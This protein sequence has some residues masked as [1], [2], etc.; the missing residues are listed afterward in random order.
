V[1]LV[2]GRAGAI[3]VVTDLQ[4]RGWDGGERLS[5][6][7][8]IGLSV[9][10][11]GEGPP[12]LSISS[13]RA[14]GER[15]V[16]TVRSAG[17]E[18]R[19]A[20][21]RLRLDEGR[22]GSGE[23]P[24][25][26]VR[27]ETLVH[28]APGGSAEAV[29]EGA[30]GA[31]ASVVVDDP[32]GIQGDDVRYVVLDGGGPPLVKVVT[33]SGDVGRDAFYVDQALKA[34]GEAGSA[35]RVEGLAAGRAESW[36]AEP[37]DGAA[38]VLLVSTRG[39][40]RRGREVIATWVRKGGGLLIAAGAEVEGD[41]TADILG[42]AVTL[43]VPTAQTRVESPPA[44]IVPVDSRHPMFRAFGRDSRSLGF[45]R[46]DRV[47]QVNGDTCRTL[48]RLTSGE[49]V[50]VECA[51][52]G[53]VLVFASD[54][55]HRWN[56]FPVHATFVPFV[57]EAV[58]YLAGARVQSQEY[59]IGDV[60][61]G[62]PPRPGTAMLNDAST[63][64]GRLVAVNVDPGESEP[65]R[66]SRDAF[67]DP[68]ARVDEPAVAGVPESAREQEDHQQLWRYALWLMLAVLILESALGARTA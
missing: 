20:R 57:Q 4:A 42:G 64:T 34:S 21:V 24:E 11:V 23:G 46:F 10:D 17:G 16:A 19:E 40:D 6:P 48:A 66:V 68:V 55:D 27:G 43:A 1:E 60:P 59:L 52:A 22:T 12:N 31:A 7:S 44:S 47:A 36:T 8:A 61:Q 35:Y 25:Q 56:D 15:V 39:L 2:G 63:G 51:G 54:L 45:V 30:R 58:R 67:F 37:L 18:A 62:I 53:R 49:P 28:V 50:L 14:A 38:A 13:V 41:V 5:V 32:G 33:A 9:E 29:L 65:E 3:V 26:K